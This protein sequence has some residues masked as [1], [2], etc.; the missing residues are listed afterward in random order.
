MPVEFTLDTGATLSTVGSSDLMK[1]GLRHSLE[2]TSVKL[3]AYGATS[4]LPVLGKLSVTMKY[5]AQ[6]GTDKIF[7]V[8][9]DHPA[10]LS[11]SA[12]SRLGLV[13][14]T[15]NVEDTLT[16]NN[17]QQQ[18]PQLFKEVGCLRDQQ[19]HL[20]VDDSVPPVAQPHRRIPFAM[21]KP[22][23]AELTRLL[24]LDIIEKTE[25]PT[26]WVSPVVLVPKPHD[27]EALR[28]CVDMRCA[29]KAICRERHV[30]PTVDDILTALNGATVFS[31]LNLN[32]GYHQLELHEDSRPI[33]TFSTHAG[34]F[35]YKCLNFGIYST[36]EVFQDTIRQ[37]LG[38]IPNVI[39]ISDD[40]LVYGTTKEDHE[41]ALEATL[42]RLSK[43][44][45]MLNPKKCTVFTRL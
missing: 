18:Y 3:F 30:T 43:G 33:T 22:L 27:Q 29:N 28:M 35:R 8:N 7:V 38:S 36:A 2:Q 39:N 1:L 45:L 20:H 5:K 32:E 4:P 11:F 26:P 42:E 25:G 16:E 24:A 37:V 34:L 10:L 40:I 41:K 12:A 13:H 21:R 9:G 44:G 17:I 23:E 31:K 6:E 19:V 14:I 15:Y